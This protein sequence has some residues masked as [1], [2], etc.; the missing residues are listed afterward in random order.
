VKNIE[1]AGEIL[2]ALWKAGVRDIV[3]CA[4]ARNA[5]FV[6]CLSAEGNPFRVHPFFEERSAGFF[7]L[8]RCVGSGRPVAVVTTSGTAAANLL[9]AT[10]ESDYQGQPL[11]LVTADRPAHYRGSGAP[12]TIVQVGLYSHY[13]ERSWDVEGSWDGSLEWSRARP[14]H[15]NVCFDEPLIDGPFSW[16]GF[17]RGAAGAEAIESPSGV[18]TPLENLNVNNLEVLKSGEHGGS[19]HSAGKRP[20]VLVGGLPFSARAEILEVL[21][22]WKRPVILEAP[23]GLRGHPDLQALE[24]LAPDKTMRALEY[25]GVIRIGSV[26]T[27]RLWRDLEK[28]QLPVVHFS[29][30]PFS[31]L[32]RTKDVFSLQDLLRNKNGFAPDA[33]GPWTEEERTQ[34]RAHAANDRQ[35]LKQYPLS[36]PAWVEWLSRQIPNEARVFIGNSL[37]IREWDFMAVRDGHHEIFANRGANGIDGLISTFLGLA[38]KEKSNWCVI[39]D[40]SAMYD[41]SGPWPNRR[42]KLRDLNLVII[43][44]SGGKIFKRLFHNELF[45]NPHDL[46]FKAWAAMWGWAYE[47]LDFPEK[48]KAN[49]GPRVI[50]IVPSET[51]TEK[52][53]RAWEAAK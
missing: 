4:G 50:E 28:S 12:Q 27:L 8:G 49:S 52:F 39:G 5:P 36:E 17:D 20:L 2:S 11:I 13:V 30:L 18:L 1:L 42:E 22:S 45:E 21:K 48:L 16:A 19:L 33:F 25:D 35:L 31:G 9:P 34:D 7:A 23:S 15:L 44:N 43:N 38:V 40:L 29:H 6:A 47:R 41:L 46:N 14:V 10:I 37:P 32:P 3:L 26:P 51:A 24:I 53:W